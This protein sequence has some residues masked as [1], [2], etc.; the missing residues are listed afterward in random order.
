[1]RRN[2]S[3]EEMLRCCDNSLEEARELNFAEQEV[4]STSLELLRN[5][6]TGE[7]ELEVVA[8]V[9]FHIGANGATIE[10]IKNTKS[11]KL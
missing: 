10:P 1:M 4:K 2:S 8:G 7:I 3:I 6:F 5:W 9:R 11:D